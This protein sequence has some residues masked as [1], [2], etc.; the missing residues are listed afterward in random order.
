MSEHTMG[1]RP[2]P[3]L[4]PLEQDAA[5]TI[6]SAEEK[7]ALDKSALPE[8]A[9]SGGTGMSQVL[10]GVIGSALQIRLVDGFLLVWTDQLMLLIVVL[11]A[12]ALGIKL[13]RD[14]TY[15]VLRGTDGVVKVRP[16][17]RPA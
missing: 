14:A 3:P 6:L 2:R 8:P 7:T 4:R 1:K 17:G 13:L 10:A 16:C 9:A 11:V 15:I 5:A 12:V